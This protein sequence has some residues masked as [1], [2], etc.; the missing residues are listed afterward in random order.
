MLFLSLNLI[1]DCSM[2]LSNWIVDADGTAVFA[3][4]WPEAARRGWAA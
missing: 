2:L 4:P 1:F 3:D